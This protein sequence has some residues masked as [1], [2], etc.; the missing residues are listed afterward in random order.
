MP[1]SGCLFIMRPFG[2]GVA[3][4]GMDGV[5]MLPGGDGGTGAVR[6]RDCSTADVSV[7]GR[8]GPYHGS[9]DSRAGGCW[10]SA[11]WPRSVRR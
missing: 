8:T 9:Q 11:D 1:S 4:A 3:Y 2:V 6:G 7:R 5:R 10:S